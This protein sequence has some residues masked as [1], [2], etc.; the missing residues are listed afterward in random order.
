MN[1][2]LSLFLAIILLYEPIGTHWNKVVRGILL[3]FL[4]Q[5][6]PV[7]DNHFVW[8]ERL[9]MRFEANLIRF[10]FPASRQPRGSLGLKE[11]R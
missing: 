6:P 8:R 7:G 3:A 1:G 9:G 10:D 5:T 4:P 11:R 2:I